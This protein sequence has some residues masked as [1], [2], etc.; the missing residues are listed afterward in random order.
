MSQL[1]VA[2]GT[3]MTQVAVS[4]A[5]PELLSNHCLKR[6][7]LNCRQRVVAALNHALG[8]LMSRLLMSNRADDDEFIG[9]P[10]DLRQFSANA[11]TFGFGFDGVE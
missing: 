11:H 7:E 10:G 5:F 3:E 8:C 4:A 9:L 6:R 2:P 1:P